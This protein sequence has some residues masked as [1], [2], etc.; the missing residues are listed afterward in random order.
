MPPRLG[1]TAR[2]WR[3]GYWIFRRIY[4]EI[5][6]IMKMVTKMTMMIAETLGYSNIR[7]EDCSS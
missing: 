7:N 6:S 2:S 1:R 4:D 3:G 5:M